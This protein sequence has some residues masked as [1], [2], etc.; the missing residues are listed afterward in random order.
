MRVPKQYPEQ[1]RADAVAMCQRGDRSIMQVSVDLGVSHWTLREWVRR[2]KMERR[3]KQKPVRERAPET[4]TLE[5][6]A[7]RLEREVER[8]MRENE[9]LQQDRDILKKAAAFFA[10]ESE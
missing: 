3:S 1:F 5:E 2:H 8:L 4:E 10:K 6:K 7:K 9:K